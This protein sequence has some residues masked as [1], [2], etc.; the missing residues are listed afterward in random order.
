[1][2]KKMLREMGFLCGLVLLAMWLLNTARG[3]PFEL[4]RAVIMIV[5]GSAG[6][7]LAEMWRRRKER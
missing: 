4:R 2:T 3:E 7:I 6:I 5:C 1:M